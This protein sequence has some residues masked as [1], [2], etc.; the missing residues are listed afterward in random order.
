M[1]DKDGK[2]L[3]HVT[4]SALAV[5]MLEGHWN[6]TEPP[7]GENNKEGKL[8]CKLNHHVGVNIFKQRRDLHAIFHN[9][10][11]DSQEEMTFTLQAVNEAG[12][13]DF[14]DPEGKVFLEIIEP[15][16]R[17]NANATVPSK[18]ALQAPLQ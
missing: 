18:S 15:L 7:L 8:V 3:L 2:H 11:S 6:I 14:K 12:R 4:Q 10:A 13:W 1:T 9:T 16:T 5:S 17:N